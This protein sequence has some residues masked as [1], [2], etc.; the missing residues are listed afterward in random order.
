MQVVDRG[1]ERLPEQQLLVAG[2]GA[3]DRGVDLV[4]EDAVGEGELARAGRGGGI[5][6]R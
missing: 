3:G 1:L 2:P 4:V 6:R 5:G